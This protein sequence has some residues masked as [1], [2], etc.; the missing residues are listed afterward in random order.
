[1]VKVKLVIW[2]SIPDTRLISQY[3]QGTR[4]LAFVF[5]L[6]RLVTLRDLIN[7]AKETVKH[8][9]TDPAVI[10]VGTK[11]DLTDKRQVEEAEIAKVRYQLG[12]EFDNDVLY[13]ETSAKTGENVEWL[14]E[15][16]AR[17]MLEIET[18]KHPS[19]PDSDGIDETFIFKV[20]LLGS[21]EVGTTSLIRRFVDDTY[22]TE[23]VSTI[24]GQFQIKELDM[25]PP[26]IDP[27]ILRDEAKKS[28]E[29]PASPT[30]APS[31]PTRT[32]AGPPA[33]P[34]GPPPAREPVTSVSV[35]TTTEGED[36]RRAKARMT[37]APPPAPHEDILELEKPEA[38]EEV[39]LEKPEAEEEVELE[40]P[41]AEEEVDE[42]VVLPDAAKIDEELLD[43]AMI[44]EKLLDAA[45]I[46]EEPPETRITRETAVSYY[47][48]MNLQK[49]YALRVKISKKQII[50]EPIDE[51]RHVEGRIEVE[52]ED[53]E[54]PLVRIVPVFPGC[55]VTPQE[56]T[57]NIDKEQTIFFYI[58][59]L[60][61]GQVD[62]RVEFW[63]RG[64]RVAFTET[65][66]VVVK[67]TIAKIFAAVGT[68]VGVIPSALEF[69]G[70]NLNEI[71]K[72]Q[73]AMNSPEVK[74]FI[75]SIGGIVLAQVSILAICLLLGGVFFYLKRPHQT[76]MET[77]IAYS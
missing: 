3:L 73:L 71:I 58:T 76:D 29:K 21:S 64:Q 68:A 48:R 26:R 61:L 1:M 10:L 8:T 17:N 55:I 34:G 2:G 12:Q 39:E 49:N 74:N 40:K 45:I 77:T 23:Y 7:L 4:G 72:N 59:P 22:S 53:Q 43:A 25:E 35:S 13:I 62:G 51:V 75:D 37:S 20:V 44:D 24:G 47:D 50:L 67:Q 16:L 36:S 70:Y 15:E 11:S 57:V 32:P 18:V 31:A 60:A 65:P 46:D 30:P 28:E 9:G 56:T 14:F 41:E 63:Y 42:D 5:D 69:L 6:S 66:T 27:T 52:R 33:P 38:E 19:L 54:L